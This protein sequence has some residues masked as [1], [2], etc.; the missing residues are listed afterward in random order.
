MPPSHDEIRSSAPGSHHRLF[1]AII[2][3]ALV[4]L[5]AARPSLAWWAQHAARGH[6]QAGRLSAADNNLARAT[7]LGRSDVITQVLAARSYRYLDQYESWRRE[8]DRARAIDPSAAS[9]KAEQRM[10]D[11]RWNPPIPIPDDEW[12]QLLELDVDRDEA[13]IAVAY[14]LLVTGEDARCE[15]LLTQWEEETDHPQQVAFLRGVAAQSKQEWRQAEEHF[16]AALELEP[17]HEMAHAALA[18]LA[19]NQGKLRLA[20][21]HFAYWAQRRPGNEQAVTGWSRVLR[22]LGRT[23]EAHRVLQRLAPSP[24]ESLPLILE[25]AHVS[26]ELGDYGEAVEYFRQADLEGPHDAITLLTAATAF[27]LHGDTMAAKTLFAYVDRISDQQGRTEVLRKRVAADGSD[28]E[29]AEELARLSQE[30]VTLSAT[31]DEQSQQIVSQLFSRHC[32]SCH[33]SRGDGDGPGSRHLYPPARDLRSERYRLVTSAN[34]FV[35]PS[36]IEA[37]IQKGIPGTAMPPFPGLSPEER[38]ALAAEVYQLR[39]QGLREQRIEHLRRVGAEVDEASV[40]RWIQQQV[41]AARPLAAPALPVLAVDDR[42]EEGRQLYRK[43]G[44]A[45]CHGEDGRG[46]AGVPLFNENG[47]HALPRDLVSEPMKGGAEPAALF[48]RLRLGM[49][50]TPHPANPALDDEQTLSLVAYCRSLAKDSSA[51]P[52]NWQR[53]GRANQRA[54]QARFGQP[55]G[56]ADRRAAGDE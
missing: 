27:A 35:L 17:E 3:V 24:E 25:W 5:L 38:Q 48:A 55:N 8:I 34:G 9:V 33:G 2:L 4:V 52:T 6:L 45:Q 13:A 21:D 53:S 16:R 7:R 37:V 40:D 1:W 54:I 30:V 15:R 41:D 11:L 49:P 28:R 42:L 47:S 19:E 51:Q 36:D 31:R 20:V 10:G 56:S 39:L 44:C 29:A 46:A 23:Q 32:A 22:R 14:G 12:K 43:S 50:G 18:Q 26:Y